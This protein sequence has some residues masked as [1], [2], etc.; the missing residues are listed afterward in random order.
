MM[1]SFGNRPDTVVMDEPFYACYLLRTGLEHPARDAILASQPTDWQAVVAQL[2]EPLQPP[3]RISYQKH[4]AHHM[5]DDSPSEWL[6]R[7]DFRHVFLIR[8]PRAMLLSLRRVLGDVTL[9]QTGLPQQVRIYR[10]VQRGTGR[11][12]VVIDADEVLANPAAALTRLCAELQIPFF[13]EMLHWP[14]GPR[15]T[16]GVWGPH[17][18]ARVY[19]STGFA[20]PHPPDGELPATCDDLLAACEDLYAQLR[21]RITH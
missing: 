20:T 6:Q 14:A 18:Y 5:L 11:E 16:D 8:Q 21:E 13:A 4:M 19:E 10:A 7:P 2:T 12:P 9:D 1:R 17:W 3:I 15:T